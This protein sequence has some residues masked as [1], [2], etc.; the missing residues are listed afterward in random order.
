MT[1]NHALAILGFALFAALVL[2]GRATIQVSEL[3]RRLGMLEHR[4][5]G[6]ETAGRPPPVEVRSP[7]AA[8]AAD[9][10]VDQEALR[11]AVAERLR[12]GRKVEAV[13][14]WRAATGQ[15]LAEAKEAIDRIAEEL[16]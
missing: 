16:G 10:A 13:K 14:L 15:G 9:R 12:A 3:R 6:L 5:R 2:L 4:V 7:P 8:T 11:E 1:D